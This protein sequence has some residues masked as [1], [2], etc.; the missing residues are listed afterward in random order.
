MSIIAA[1][2][3]FPYDHRTIAQVDLEERLHRSAVIRW[4]AQNEARVKAERKRLADQGYHAQEI[5]PFP[6]WGSP[7]PDP[8]RHPRTHRNTPTRPCQR[9]PGRSA[10]GTAG[11]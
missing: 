3:H 10:G 1:P 11:H 8:A 5:E 2:A 6:N 7:S 4:D 9:P